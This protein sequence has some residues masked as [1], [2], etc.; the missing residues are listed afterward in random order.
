MPSPVHAPVAHVASVAF[1]SSAQQASQATTQSKKEVNF[2]LMNPKD[3]LDPARLV[4]C[5]PSKTSKD[6]DANKDVTRIKYRE[7]GKNKTLFLES[8]TAM[9][10]TSLT[11]E[12]AVEK[13]VDFDLYGQSSTKN[14]RFVNKI[15]S[16]EEAAM[17]YLLK[18][19]NDVQPHEEI[20]SGTARRL[21]KSSLR[22]L[23]KA[24][25]HSIPAFRVSTEDFTM[26]N[27]F[28]LPSDKD[29]DNLEEL[30]VKFIVELVGVKIARRNKRAQLVWKLSQ[31]KVLKDEA[32]KESKSDRLPIGVPN[33]TE[34]DDE[35][36]Q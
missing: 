8:A 22:V 23:E 11:I 16:I 3:D 33:F 34:G 18:N 1:D 21:I 24:K 20:N 15:E 17:D 32:E 28:D 14:S 29:I 5:T 9:T 4:F 36:N 26:E 2:V 7:G 13:W 35:D 30:R 19:T 31:V 12:G 6:K 25:R 27:I 10:R